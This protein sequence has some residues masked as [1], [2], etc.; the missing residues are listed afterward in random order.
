MKDI[1]DNDHIGGVKQRPRDLLP[2]WI[3]VFIW[4]FMIAG[5]FIPIVIVVGLLGGP[6]SLSLYGLETYYPFSLI[7]LVISS[8]MALKGVV[9]F[10]LWFEKKWAVK[11]AMLDAII[12]LVTCIFVMMLR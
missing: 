1:L 12:G 9:A 2:I 10:G 6:T 7:G 3:K 8:L 4:L 11:L 5:V